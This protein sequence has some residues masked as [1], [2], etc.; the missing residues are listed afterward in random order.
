GMDGMALLSQ[1]TMPTKRTQ[2]AWV[3]PDHAGEKITLDEALKDRVQKRATRKYHAKGKMS[4]LTGRLLGSC[5]RT[6]IYPGNGYLVGVLGVDSN[7]EPTSRL[8]LRD[9]Q[10]RDHHFCLN[11]VGTAVTVR[12]HFEG[13]ADL[14]IVV[15]LD[16]GV[17]KREH[18]GLAG[19]SR[20]QD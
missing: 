12:D 15:D 11:V 19:L 18:L 5:H 14:G 8:K 17:G 16:A 1:K 2:H 9:L 13:E 4:T 20:L 10:Q 7:Q 3:F 6:G